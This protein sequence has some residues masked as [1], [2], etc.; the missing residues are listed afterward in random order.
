[1]AD[2]ARET[3]EEPGYQFKPSDGVSLHKANTFRTQQRYQLKLFMRSQRDYH[4][5]L[6]ATVDMRMSWSAYEFQKEMN[7]EE[8]IMYP[9]LGIDY[10][11]PVNPYDH[12]RKQNP[13]E[14]GHETWLE[15]FAKTQEAAAASEDDEDPY[16]TLP[17]ANETEEMCARRIW[18][19]CQRARY[20]S[21]RWTERQLR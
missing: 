4:P 15:E 1:M 20:P 2:A 9:D 19:N 18:L 16:W 8:K 17:E 6:S 12:W 11:M 10:S 21:S 13:N 7:E 14:A 3:A 5:G